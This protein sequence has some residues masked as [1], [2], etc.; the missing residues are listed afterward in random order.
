LVFFH[1][2]ILH[3][4][5]LYIER[6][7]LLDAFGEDGEIYLNIIVAERKKDRSCILWRRTT[8]LDAMTMESFTNRWQYSFSLI[9]SEQGASLEVKNWIDDIRN[10]AIVI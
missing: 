5:V 2:R 8:V 10:D 4:L 7:G 9:D 1:G 6:S 3:E